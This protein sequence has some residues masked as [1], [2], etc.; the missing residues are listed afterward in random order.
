MLFTALRN[1][2]GLLVQILPCAALCLLPFH[3]RFRW[4]NRRTYLVAAGILVI[5]L[6]PFTIISIWPMDD[7]IASVRTLLQNVI[8]L[9]ALAAL[10]ALYIRSVQAGTW[11]KAFVFFLVM[12]YGFVVTSLGNLIP[13]ALGIPTIIG[14]LYSPERLVVL[15]VLNAILFPLMARFLAAVRDLSSTPLDDHDWHSMTFVP[16]GTVVI[17]L[18]GL[19]LPGTKLNHEELYYLMLFTMVMLTAALMWWSMNAI[20][21]A[22]VKARRQEQLRSA[23]ERREMQKIDL[24]HELAQAKARVETLE[25]EIAEARA[26]NDATSFEPVRDEPIVLATANQAVSFHPSDVLYVESVNRVRILHLVDNEAVRVP[27]SLSQIAEQLPAGLFAYCHRSIV[28]NLDRLAELTPTEA[29]LS[30]GT[31]IPVSRRRFSELSDLL[32]QRA[33]G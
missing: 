6:V 15:I 18:V 11:Q 5:A 13:G 1:I 9:A 28:V 12:C 22:A 2:V 27:I 8:F 25:R 14:S 16:A 3:G 17:M 30:D 7:L 21:S 20:R 29:T 4:D 26:N 10:L 24:M 19:W 33:R 31:K 32:A 23:L